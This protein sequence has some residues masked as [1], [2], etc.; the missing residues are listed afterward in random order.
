MIF[1]DILYRRGHI[2]TLDPSR[3]TADELAV[4]DGRVLATGAEG[5][6]EYLRGP[7]TRVLDLSSYTVVP[8][9]HD[10]H[11]HIL[12]F[13]FSLVEVNVRAAT[14]LAQVVDA[15][16][17]RVGSTPIG[18]WIRGGGY[19]ENKLM[20]RRHPSRIDLDPISRDHPVFLSHISGHMGVANAPA[21]ALA[22]IDRDTP[23]PT[24]GVIDRDEHGEPTGLLKETAQEL[25]K[26]ILPPYTLAE[27][28]TAL[29]AA[30][31]QMAAEGITSA[32]DAWAG[33]IAPEE[34]RAY[35][36]ASS[37]GL[38]PQRVRV[39]VDVETL[40][41]R[42][43]RFDFA[44]GLHTGFGTQRLRLGAIKI[45][46]DGSLIGKTAA[47]S[48]PYASDP[49]TCGMLV[50]S[51]ERIRE[52][53]R[54]AYRGGWQLAMHAIGDRA[55]EVGLDAIESEM[56]PEAGR[57]RPRIEHCGVLRPDL[58]ERIRR[59]GAV[60][61]TQP[62][63]V[64]ELGDGF[65]AALGEGRIPL[66]YPLASLQGLPVALSSDRPVVNGAPLLA[67]RD[68]I[69]RCTASG[70]PYA[71]QE[72]IDALQ[73]LQWYT[74]GSA[75]STFE[76]QENGSLTAGKWADFAVLAQNPLRVDPQALGEI[77][78]IDTVVAG[79]PRLGNL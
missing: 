1:A 36:D 7:S 40:T 9:F 33:W 5:E 23:D 15:V 44:F 29:T 79:V 27:T 67:I 66:T 24:G 38:L 8:G 64:S 70:N 17:T 74:L 26:K 10:A 75:Y 61:V 56:G 58:V 60:I 37:E 42:E 51:E 53:V 14:K 59:L 72:Q 62:R 30:G 77:R 71:P 41:I 18:G 34:F 2:V 11:C 76:E 4:K 31:K 68:A 65:R 35:Q 43:G 12:L 21:L 54:C 20:E 39:M 45:F 6:L 57:F 25:I 63:F 19:N 55:I 22:R 50:K 3:S 28:K 69:L 78:V 46:L 49:T 32:Q 13:G 47:L 52:Q 73:A 16:A 48:T